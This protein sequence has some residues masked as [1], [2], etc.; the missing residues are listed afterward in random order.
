MGGRG[1]RLRLARTANSHNY[2]LLA[3]NQVRVS[4]PEQGSNERRRPPNRHLQLH[5]LWLQDW[6]RFHHCAGQVPEQAEQ[7]EQAEKVTKNPTTVSIVS[8]MPRPGNSTRLASTLLA[9]PCLDPSCLGSAQP[10]PSLSLSVCHCL[11]VVHNL[12]LP[13]PQPPSTRH[14]WWLGCLPCGIERAQAHVQCDRIFRFLFC[15]LL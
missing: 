1:T 4:R 15:F 12:K 13:Q 5:L 8:H 6:L 2:N 7:P 3:S 9:S 14:A 10:A 11:C